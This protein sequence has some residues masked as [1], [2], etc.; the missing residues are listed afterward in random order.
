MKLTELYTHVKKD[1]QQI[2]KELEQTI[3]SQHPIMQNAGNQ[4]LKAGGKRIRPVFVVL[5]GHFGNYDIEP[6]KRWQLLLK[7]SIWLRSFTMM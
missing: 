7:P 2:E 5:S 6:V 3:S 1:L 4:L